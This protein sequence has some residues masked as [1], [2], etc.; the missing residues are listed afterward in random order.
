MSPSTKYNSKLQDKRILVLGGTSGIGFCVAEAARESGATVLVS[1][2]NRSKLENAIQR[3]HASCPGSPKGSLRGY[4]KDLS[5]VSTLESSLAELF[6]QVT[7]AGKYKLDHIVY[8]AGNVVGL[9]KLDDLDTHMI[10]ANGI[11]RFYVPIMVGKI[12]PKYM[13]Q[14]HESS[15]SFTSGY[16]NVK[17]RAGRVLMAG[18]AAGVEGVARALAVDLR[19]IRVNCVCPGAVHTELFDRMPKHLLDP[20]V[21]KYVS[22]TLTGT[23]GQPEQAAEAYLYC[24]RDAFVDGT[25]VHS[26]GGY[27]LG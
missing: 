20:L 23:I 21:G 16:S 26:N 4:A 8:T 1:G 14:S 2:S 10:T 22:G 25:V 17:P 11:M 12:A 13:I 27:L 6:E 9:V 7:E 24:M 19:P 3:I 18:W 5:D 15:I